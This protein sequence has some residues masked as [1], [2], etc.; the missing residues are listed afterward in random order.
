MTPFSLFCTLVLIR[1]MFAPCVC[2]YVCVTSS[3]WRSGGHEVAGEDSYFGVIHAKVA[4]FLQMEGAV[5]V[6]GTHRAIQLPIGDGC[7]FCCGSDPNTIK[8][9]ISF[10]SLD[11]HSS[12]PP[13]HHTPW[14]PSSWQ[15]DRPTL[16][17]SSGYG[18]RLTRRASTACF[19][20]MAPSSRS[21]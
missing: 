11:L 10:A 2:V 13:Y 20:A 9:S 15:S 12:A 3:R 18:G 8:T 6:R 4:Y 17:V 14:G 5:R 19:T 7:R 16:T 21:P 1:R